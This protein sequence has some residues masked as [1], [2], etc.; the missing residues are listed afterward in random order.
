MILFFRPR[1]FIGRVIL[2]SGDPTFL[3]GCQPC[4]KRRSAAA[5]R[6]L[7]TTI[8]ALACLTLGI[9]GGQVIAYLTR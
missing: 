6:G 4:R 3:C 2:R 8:C 7:L 9:M 1:D 5:A